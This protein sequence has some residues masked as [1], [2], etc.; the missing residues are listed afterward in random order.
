MKTL[1]SCISGY[2]LKYKSSD[3]GAKAEE[4][5]IHNDVNDTECQTVSVKLNVGLYLPSLLLL[6]HEM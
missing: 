1:S 6:I 2:K 3:E 5:F 4:I